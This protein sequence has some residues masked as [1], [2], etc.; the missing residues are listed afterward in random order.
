MRKPILIVASSTAGSQLITL[1]SMTYAARFLGP[2]AFGFY[3]I[4]FAFA[5]PIGL[6]ATLRLETAFVFLNN[7]PRVL[8]AGVTACVGL[9]MVT[10]PILLYGLTSGRDEVAYVGLLSFFLG[11]NAVIINL[12]NYRRNY[13]KLAAVRLLTALM[14]LVL[15][16]IFVQVELS[17]AL[18]L[19]TICGQAFGLFT[20]LVLHARWIHD[21]FKWPSLRTMAHI[22]RENVSFSV[23]NG[24]QSLFSA[25]QETVV[26]ILITNFLGVASVGIY[27]FANRILRA[28]I[29]LTSEAIGRV[30][31]VQIRANQDADAA[32]RRA[33]I[34][35]LLRLL[36]LGACGLALLIFFAAAP[37]LSWI[38]DPKWAGLDILLPAMSLYISALFV[39]A[40]VA[41]F[42]LALGQPRAVSF[43][44]IF[45]TSLYVLCVFVAL[46]LGAELSAAYWVVSAIMPTYFVIF[47]RKVRNIVAY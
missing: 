3:A 26:V 5:V 34:D 43:L 32:I 31:Q 21:N 38:L 46:M 20:G 8:L 44:G 11:M 33:Y 45:G 30:L 42:P 4:V 23:F 10:T 7:E 36:V 28:P 13:P 40:T 17:D 47:V 24:A 16:T 14:T 27:S 18:T 9:A 39:G 29:S 22:L 2:E 19:A 1:I 35:R 41:V 12:S 37:V 15:V 6:I 25:L